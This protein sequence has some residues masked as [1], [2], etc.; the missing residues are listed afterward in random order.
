ML[1]LV[2]LISCKYPA[3]LDRWLNGAPEDT[4]DYGWWDS[5]DTAWGESED[6]GPAVA[7]DLDHDGDGYTENQGDC[8]DFDPLI[9][10]GAEEGIADGIDQDCDLFEL[11]YLDGDQDG[12]GLMPSLCPDMHCQTTGFSAV[13]G[14][15]SDVDDAIH[16]NAIEVCDEL[17]NNC[18]ILIDD[19]DPEVNP[20]S[21]TQWWPDQDGDGFG[22]GTS[23][24]QCSRPEG[25]ADNESDCDDS[26]VILNAWDSDQDG[27]TSCDGDCDDQDPGVIECSN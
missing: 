10:P 6:T 9:H 27:V 25:F 22:A 5:G 4:A 13:D 7:W 24:L 23:V 21:Q 20:Q 1:S 11:C 17:D 18:N 16:P 8:D 3:W 14:D 2:L 15:C 26:T 12:F 19:A